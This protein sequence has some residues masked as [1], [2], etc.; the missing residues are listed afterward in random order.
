MTALDATTRFLLGLAVLLALT[1]LAGRVA[2]RVGQPPVLAEVLVG[3]ALG[4]TLLGE[5]LPGVRRALF[6]PDV[7]PMINGL[8]QV[9]LALYAFEIG[10]HLAG[11]GPSE[12]G[13]GAPL[14]KVTAASLLAPAGA[15]LVLT[16]AFHAHRLDGS[17]GGSA[18]LAV[19]LACALGVTAVPVLA[20][21][22]QDRALEHTG[23]G[24]LSLA[25]ASLGDGV[26]WT[27]LAVALWLGGVIGPL[28]VAAG[29]AAALAAGVLIHRRQ[30]RPRLPAAAS[31]AGGGRWGLVPLLAA[32]CVAAAGSSALGLHPMLGALLLGAAWPGEVPAQAAAG[33]R[34]LAAA[35]LPCFFLGTGQLVNVGAALTTR[36][37]VPLVLVLLL[38]AGATKLIACT[39][40]GLR[41]GLGLRGSLRLGVLMN[42]KGLTEIVVLSAGYQAGLIG[43]TLFEAL[44]VVALVTTVLAGPAL[45]LLDGRPEPPGA[46]AE[47]D[48]GVQGRPEARARPG[49]GVGAGIGAGAE[50]DVGA[51]D[52][53]G[54]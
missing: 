50:G 47:P 11:P 39:V 46:P 45:A 43:R 38:S 49:A 8:G 54:W 6:G 7:M 35:L 21:L 24:R 14:L 28:Q 25:S 26:C 5:L 37:F 53:A 10:G 36:G 15:A 12:R 2:T 18:E 20:R 13:S 27:L 41:A 23:V 34:S 3:V 52:R 40:V 44:V 1:R 48:P 31:A 9:G 19:F 29:A 51:E 30:T 32:I 22:L 33:V 42:A 4:P 17:H 16:S